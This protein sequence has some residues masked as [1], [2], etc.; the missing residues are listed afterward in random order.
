MVE[1]QLNYVEEDA[2]YGWPNS[3]VVFAHG[4]EYFTIYER[5]YNSWTIKSSIWL[6]L[7]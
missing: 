2:H 5:G 7:V 6:S 3:N 4:S 1:E